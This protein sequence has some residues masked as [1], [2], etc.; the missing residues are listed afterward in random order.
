[1]WQ[2]LY[3]NM[4]MYSLDT[5]QVRWGT[6]Y[7]KTHMARH[8]LLLML[9]LPCFISAEATSL[10]LL[11]LLMTWVI[12]SRWR[13]RKELLFLVS[14]ILFLLLLGVPGA[15]E[16][17]MFAVVK[18]VWYVGKVALAIGAG[19]VLSRYLSDFKIVCRIVILAGS[20]A[21]VVHLVEIVLSFYAGVSFRNLWSVAGF[22]GY[23]VTLVA[24]GMM[25]S[26]P[27]KDLGYSWIVHFLCLTL[28]IVSLLVSFSR[29]F[30]ISYVVIV[31]MLRGWGRLSLKTFLKIACCLL[32]SG[33]LLYLLMQVNADGSKNLVEKI[34]HSVSEVSLKNYLSMRDINLN[35][36]GF[37][38]YCA[39]LDYQDGTLLQQ[40]FGQ[41]LGATVDLGFYMNLG[42]EEI[43]HLPILHNGYLSILV[44]FGVVGLLAYLY[45]VLR[46]IRA[47]SYVGR[48]KSAALDE[49]RAGRLI[50]AIG[51][52]LLLTTFVIA[53]PF[54][55][56]TLIPTLVLLGL[57]IG[58]VGQKNHGGCL[59]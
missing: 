43:R 3:R 4:Q 1:M 22:K 32:F 41:G 57:L 38:S 13:V 33:L 9:L 14:P 35:W 10:V 18:D 16:Y 49:L 47:T 45:F 55:K 59:R 50:A 24:L 19:Y 56:I 5:R 29:T 7:G 39:L 31:V 27:K 21:A 25:S 48:V 34:V 30:I 28:C 44:K 37:E 17:P 58:L 40:I 6:G 26:F 42:G 51:W 12:L 23:F 20:I 53:G 2:L 36:R 8:S 11:L 54:N 46:V 52:C 15:L